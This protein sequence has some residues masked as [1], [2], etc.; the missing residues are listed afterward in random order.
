MDRKSQRFYS[1][2]WKDYQVSLHRLGKIG[3]VKRTQFDTRFLMI[4]RWITDMRGNPIK[5]KARVVWEALE[6]SPAY[7]REM[8]TFLNASG[9]IDPKEI[10][11]PATTAKKPHL[12]RFVLKVDTE[13]GK[14]QLA[15]VGFV[16]QYRKYNVLAT[17]FRKVP[18]PTKIATFTPQDKELLEAFTKLLANDKIKS[19]VIESFQITKTDITL[20]QELNQYIYPI[21]EVLRD[22]LSIKYDSIDETGVDGVTLAM[23]RIT[24]ALKLLS[25]TTQ[26]LRAYVAS[27]LL[28]KH[29]DYLNERAIKTIDYIEKVL[30]KHFSYAG[31]YGNFFTETEANQFLDELRER[32]LTWLDKHNKLKEDYKNALIKTEEVVT[33]RIESATS[34]QFKKLERFDKARGKKVIYV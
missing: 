31:K 20:M 27:S 34:E 30:D 2:Y 14:P 28:R 11:S 23:N 6:N 15:P 19:K 29:F 32:A 21:L 5:P 25:D 12:V 9:A 24:W 18:T 3:K 17:E 1:Q 13:T 8:I 7:V 26:K 33:R 22:E 4:N 10:F 16:G